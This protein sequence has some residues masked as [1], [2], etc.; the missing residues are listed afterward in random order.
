MIRGKTFLKNIRRY[1][2]LMTVGSAVRYALM[3][4]G[5]GRSLTKIHLREHGKEPIFLRRSG[6]DRFTFTE[7][8]E[9]NVYESLVPLMANC[10]TMV[11]LGANIGLT[12]RY[13][14]HRF[15]QLK[16]LAVEAHPNSFSILK[17]NLAPFAANG[18]AK[19]IHAAAWST[20]GTVYGDDHGHPEHYSR[21]SV[22][23]EMGKVR[24]G[25]AQ[26]PAYKLETLFDTHHLPHVDLLKIDIEGTET[27]L[28][29]NDLS[30]ASRVRMIA[31]EFHKGSRKQCKFDELFSS[32][33][34]LIFDDGHT[35]VAMR[36]QES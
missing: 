25:T 9:D 21:F 24:R 23:Q 13:F 22:T 15:P 31:V 29:K 36:S 11:D 19:A 16:V 10:E 26:I 2:K 18:R 14:L 27:E 33:W 28:F 4:R 32:G 12:S 20:N 8:Y 7:V 35:V 6:S 30:W 1:S 3:L 17:R 5:S 34:N